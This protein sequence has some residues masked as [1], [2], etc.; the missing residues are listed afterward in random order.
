MSG[1]LAPSS[2][3]RLLGRWNPGAAP[4]YRELSD[5][6]RLLVLDGRIPLD[7]ALPSER[8]LATALGIS[9]TTV[10]AAYAS[11]REQGLLRGGQGSRGRTGVPGPEVNVA[12]RTTGPGLGGGPGLAVPDGLL[13][14]AYAS[15]PASGEVVH[16][17][18]AAALTELPA[19]LP[20]F[21]YDALGVRALREAVAARYS[22][23]GVPTAAAQILVTSGAQHALNIVLRTLTGRADR[24]L[25]ENPSYP[26]ALDAIRAAGC[27]PVPVAM[28]PAAPRGQPSAGPL[29][30]WDLDAMDSAL[31]QRPALAYVIPDFH[32]PT[33]RLMRD[34]QRRRLVRAAAASGTVLVVDETLRELNLDAEAATPMAAF[35]PAVVSIGSL[36]KSHWAGLRTGWIRADEPLIQRF[37]AARTTM[38]LGGPVVEQL[39]AAHLV[40][41][42]T[43]PLPARLGML[44]ENREALLS[45]VAEH[46]PSWQA[47]RPDGG[48]S[49]WC[50]LPAPV[51][52]ALAVIAPDF[53][54]RLAAGPRFGVGGALEHYLRVPFTLPSD[55]LETA[56]LAL[57]AAQH[58]LDSVPTLRRHRSAL[59]AVAIA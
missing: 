49:I 36:S 40:N 25:V 1:S 14:L 29:S 24:V 7:V 43:E 32:N 47:E 13:D 50:R 20:G 44:R 59:P 37:A 28:P 12:V 33:G 45:L 48:L 39:A 8:S 35:S 34:P 53:G 30:G 21:G 58:R 42:L 6:V 3:A 2:L 19:L 17:A 31:Q 51:S 10:T 11:L 9:R 41:S 54:L 16:R 4:A 52:T 23:A 57:R 5:V 46:L 15:L 26:H 27:R 22:A 18:F 56:V 55:Q 38:D